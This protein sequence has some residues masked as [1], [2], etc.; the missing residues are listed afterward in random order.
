MQRRY[1]KRFLSLLYG[2]LI[3]SFWFGH[4]LGQES[5]ADPALQR[6]QHLR[7]LL[8][9]LEGTSQTKVRVFRPRG[10]YV[11]FILAP[12]STHFPVDSA[13][14]A[15]PQQAA[16]RFLREHSGLFV[17]DS[18]A[19][20]FDVI[21]IKSRN[22]RSYLRYRQTY[23]G[24]EVFAAQMIVKVNAA[25]GIE[26]V[27]SDIMVE[28]T[29]LDQ[30]EI[31]LS[32]TL[33]NTTAQA[34][35]LAFLA[36]QYEQLTFE[37]SEAVL[38]VF[39]PAVVGLGG[40]TRLVWQTEVSDT[41]E[42][43]VRESVF[44]DAHSGDV[45]F[46]Y[47]LIK[48]A[49]NRVIQDYDGSMDENNYTLARS[50]G[51]PETGIAD[52]DDTYDYLGDVN[53]FY[54][55]NHGR[56]SYDDNDADREARV[57]WGESG[58]WWDAVDNFMVIA[59]D[60]VTDDT[61][62]HEF[63]HG[64]FDS[65]F[66]GMVSKSQAIEESFCDMWG[67]WID[68]DNGDAG[69]DWYL[70]EDWASTP[71]PWRRMDRPDL[72]TT[73]SSYGPAFGSITQP[74]KLYGNG[75]Y[76]GDQDDYGAHHNLGVGNKLCYLLTDGDT[77]N[78]YSIT[79]LGISKAS[80]LFYECMTNHLTPGMD[81]YAVGGELLSSADDISLTSTEKQEV[82]EACMAVEILPALMGHWGLNEGSGATAGDSTNI[83]EVLPSVV[84][85]PG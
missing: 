29:V 15:T 34:E 10:G 31:S 17:N 52:V 21:R 40:P 63:T 77:F 11:S 83:I 12:P 76:H 85:R 60:E 32:P 80:D 6:S 41:G 51:D 68:Q 39:S 14:R 16:D 48:E 82:E 61:V 49:K 75:W 9:S 25:G 70:F 37:A 27:S 69:T 73:S 79:G 43:V 66:G 33:S 74:D 42:S 72:V 8:S 67:E 46:R 18:P 55:S 45:A 30:G 19:V 62:G 22:N 50:E 81:Y 20:G 56:R 65:E 35:A 4:A 1:F 47:P 24:L 36:D 44:I 26:S 3:L 58:A 28:T 71:Y 59:E 64:V 53:D 23:G 13:A 78:G 38:K 54:F 7:T 5:P 57:R 84:I 2:I